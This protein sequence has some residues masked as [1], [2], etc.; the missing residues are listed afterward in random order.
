MAPDPACSGRTVFHRA[1]HR[2][3][4]VKRPHETISRGESR[5]LL[6]RGGQRLPDVVLRSSGGVAVPDRQGESVRA[7]PHR[8]VPARALVD[9]GAQR[10]DPGGEAVSYTH[11][12][13]HETDSYL[14]C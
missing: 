10:A 3:R 2:I 6:A 1:L 11:L 13:A 5:G 14:V 8:A 4:G 9:E 12:R 7:V